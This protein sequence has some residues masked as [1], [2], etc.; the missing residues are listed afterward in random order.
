MWAS[1]VLTTYVATPKIAELVGLPEDLH[2][3]TPHYILGGSAVLAFHRW[4]EVLSDKIPASAHFS[5]R[6]WCVWLCA[7][8]CEVR[9]DR[10]GAAVPPAPGFLLRRAGTVAKDLALLVL[11]R[12]R[13]AGE[14]PPS[15]R[16]RAAASLSSARSDLRHRRGKEGP[17]WR[18]CVVRHWHAACMLSPPRP[19]SNPVGAP[20]VLVGRVDLAVPSGAARVRARVIAAAGRDDAVD[21]DAA[22]ARHDAAHEQLRWEQRP[23]DED[24]GRSNLQRSTRARQGKRHGTTRNLWAAAHA[25]VADAELVGLESMVAHHDDFVRHHLAHKRPYQDI[26]AVEI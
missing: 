1:A 4:M 6:Y 14:E 12:R 7:P 19:R 25:C 21:D 24:S 11:A 10:Q 17:G 13:A 8:V 5:F 15:T 2:H 9:F 23:R 22:D 20:G 16:A 26:S 18:E 3:A